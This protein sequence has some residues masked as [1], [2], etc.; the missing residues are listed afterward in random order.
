MRGNLTR[1]VM[2]SIAAAVLLL[3]SGAVNGQDPEELRDLSRQKSAAVKLMAQNRY[4]EALRI[5]EP[6]SKRVPEHHDIAELLS[7]CY[8]RTGRPEDAI[9]LLEK[10]LEK[11]PGHIGFVKNLGSA[12]LDT[13]DREGALR[14]W[15]SVLTADA[16]T[17]VNYRTIADLEWQAGMYERAIETLSEGRR[18]RKYFQ[19]YTMEIIRMERLLGRCSDAFREGLAYLDADKDPMKS[20]AS[21]IIDI[22]AEC[23]GQDSL[24]AEV[25]SV[26]ASGGKNGRYFHLL[27]ALLL[28]GRDDYSLASGLIS[29]EDTLK[30]DAEEAYY[31]AGSIFDMRHKRRSDQYQALILKAIETF[32][33][34]YSRSPIIPQMMLLTARYRLESGIDGGGKEDFEEAASIAG[35]VISHPSGIAFR[36]A[37][38]L[39]KASI[40]LEHLYRPK[41]AL[42]TLESFKWRQ[43]GNLG[44]RDK[45]RMKAL[46]VSGE[47]DRASSLFGDYAASRDST[48][49]AMGEYAT[50]MLLFLFGEHRAAMDSLSAMAKRSPWSEWANDALDAAIMIKAAVDE[51][52]E[53]LDLYSAALK[54]GANG[55]FQDAAASLAALEKNHPGS[56]VA[57][58]A[59]FLRAGMREKSGDAAG[60]VGD[61]ESLA[62][63]FPLDEHAAR[64]LER[65]ALIFEKDDREAALEYYGRLLERYPDYPFSVRVRNRYMALERGDEGKNAGGGG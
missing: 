10:R 38:A 17:A 44:E 19:P 9:E 41:D 58:R 2:M 1:P 29:G 55:R 62:E 63:R 33:R 59:I 12:L 27:K 53:A 15:H 60:A 25:D 8:I 57:P 16:R 49:A 39:L 30:L 7:T 37:A 54:Q 11:V 48:V 64:A 40:E 51:G 61:L 65:I 24:L 21:F 52:E 56:P 31:L 4:S 50:G 18:F 43:K 45:L 23:P 3:S 5:L 34:D 47:R 13:G 6:I 42:A 22:F 26:A 28:A 32:E 14:V 20:R 46:L 36:E 35:R